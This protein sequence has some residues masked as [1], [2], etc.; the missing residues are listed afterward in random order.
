MFGS[1]TSLGVYVRSS[2]A[3]TFAL[4]LRNQGLTQ[5][6]KQDFNVGT[7]N[8][9][10]KLSLQ[11]IA[12]MPTGSGSWGTLESDTSY[13]IGIALGAGST[14]QSST[15]AAWASGNNFASSSQANL[16]ATNGATFDICLIQH[17][18]GPVCTP[19]Q[20]DDGL[21]ETVI[22]CKRYYRKSYE[23]G[24]FAGSSATG[25]GVFHL[26]VNTSI[27]FAFAG[28]FEI[29]MRVAPTMTFYNAN[30]GASG[31]AYDDTS[32]ANLTGVTAVFV[33][34]VGYERI[35]YTT[36]GTAGDSILANYTAEAGLT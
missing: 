24:T 15:N 11:N 8:V 33:T 26:E 29:P 16:I 14:F 18:T 17:E 10:Q 32:G 21:P 31:G 20:P 5:Y 30:T 34:T 19:F 36:G 1:T 4:A 22:K 2:V 7:P 35:S 12:A 28:R 9:W 13:R 6:Y 25:S 27:A 23:L 3:G